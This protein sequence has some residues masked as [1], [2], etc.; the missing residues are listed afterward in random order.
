M[1]FDYFVLPFLLG[2]AF[3]LIY[4][5]VTY[6][7]WFIRLGKEDRKAV[8]KGFFSVKLFAALKEIVFESLLHRKIFRKNML[9]GFMHMSLAFGWFL[10]IVMGNFESRVYEPSAMNPPYVPIFFKFFNTTIHPFPLHKFFS[11][12]MDLLLL[13]VLTGV[14]LALGKR[15]LSRAYGMKRTTRLSLSDRMAMLSLWFIFPLRLAAESFTHAVYGSGEFLTG[16]MGNFLGSFLPASVL[17]YPAWWA[18]SVSLG[19]FFVALPFSRYMHIPTEVVL[20]FSRHFGLKEKREHT[21][22]TDIEVR[23]C[24]RCGICIDTCQLAFAGGIKNVQSAYQLRAI[25]YHQIKSSEHLN[26]MMCGRCET[27]CPVGINIKDVRLI[28][29]NELNG[30]PINKEEY[31]KVNLEPVQADVIYF[32][33][34]MTHQTPSIKKSMAKILQAA[35]IRYWFM[36]ESGGVCCGRPSILTGHTE[37]AE[38]IMKSNIEAI[39]KSHAKR[40]VTSC[41]ICYKVFNQDYKL[42]MEVLHHTQ[43]IHEMLNTNKIQVSGLYRRAVYHDP[44]ELSRDIRV[45]DEPRYVLQKMVDLVPSSYE[46]DSSLCC[47][48]SLANLSISMEKRLEITRDACDRLTEGN[49]GTLVTSCP[50][51]KKTFEKAAGIPVKDIAEI[52]C[53][54]MQKY[55]TVQKIGQMQENK[56]RTGAKNQILT[57][58]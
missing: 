18:Y 19:V 44:C 22:I 48:G 15:I 36:D 42:D 2:M 7:L 6:A 39:R 23:S 29:R 12:L 47:G 21:P 25:R 32:G 45:Y 10:L 5:A 52:V 49:P 33:G 8:R 13:I 43:F 37:Q 3:L 4:L 41:P 34:C 38:A 58:N 50:Q 46:K 20:I 28:S 35:G 30:Y 55:E 1:K 14:V 24:S 31:A 54:G 53:E 16:T 40:L 56:S 57:A 26:C 51:C 27:A 17:F 11:V 9:L